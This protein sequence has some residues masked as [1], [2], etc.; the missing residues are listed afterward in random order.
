MKWICDECSE[1]PCIM[2]SYCAGDETPES[3]TWGFHDN[4]KWEEV[5]EHGDPQTDATD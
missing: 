4:A 2:R 1:S 3:C 5:G